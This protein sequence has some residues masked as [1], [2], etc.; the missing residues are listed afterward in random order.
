MVNEKYIPHYLFQILHGGQEENI[1]NYS[2]SRKA[3]SF[4]LRISQFDM[5]RFVVIQME[6]SDCSEPARLRSL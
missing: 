6:R 5:L 4:F 1:L 2:L 3:K